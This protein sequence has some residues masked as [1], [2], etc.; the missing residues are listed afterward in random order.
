[1][2]GSSKI[3]FLFLFSIVLFFIIFTGAAADVVIYLKN[4]EIVKVPVNK[5]DIASIS[6]DEKSGAGAS[7]DWGFESGTLSGWEK[8][9]LSFNN[10][11]T[12]GDNPTARHRAEPSR[13]EGNYWIGTYENRSKPEDNPGGVQ[14]EEPK[15]VLVSVPFVIEKPSITFLIG[16]GCNVNAERA[17]LVING[18][19]VLKATG[20][21][22]E[23][24]ERQSW[25]VSPYIGQRAQ[26]RLVD[27]SSGEW[28][29]IN[30]DDVRFE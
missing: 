15:G 19:A 10:Q 17:E 16:G 18:E 13:H 14:G 2:F 28:G 25:D 9:G 3:P 8:K 24:M 12:Y 1:M 7:I 21:C 11:P 27:A 6:F 26:I 30:F 4:G 20:Q 22:R 29:H 23:T 5:E